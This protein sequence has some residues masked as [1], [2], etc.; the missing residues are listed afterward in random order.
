MADIVGTADFR[1]LGMAEC[2]LGGHRSFDHN[3]LGQFGEFVYV[4][5]KSYLQMILM[6]LQINKNVQGESGPYLERILFVILT[7]STLG[8]ESCSGGA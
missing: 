2:C 5:G 4:F 3:S 1:C 6:R 7:F 8:R